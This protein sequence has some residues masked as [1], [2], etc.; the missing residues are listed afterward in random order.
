MSEDSPQCVQSYSVSFCDNMN[1]SD[2]TPLLGAD[3]SDDELDPSEDRTTLKPNHMS[4]QRE[5]PIFI[6]PT[7]KHLNKALSCYSSSCPVNSHDVSWCNACHTRSSFYGGP[8]GK[9]PMDQN[10]DS[11]AKS[12]GSNSGAPQRMVYC[13]HGRPSN[14]CVS[15]LN[16]QNNADAVS[17]IIL[18]DEEDHCHRERK[19]KNDKKAR[20]KLWFASILCLVFM[21]CEIVGGYFSGSLAIATDAAHLLTDFASFMISLIALWVASRPATKQ[22]PFGWYRA[23]VLGAL[24]SVL[25]IWVVTGILLYIAIE[26]VIT[27]NFD[28]EP[29]IMLYTSVFG[30]IVNVLMGC[31][32]HQ[33]S[34]SHGGVREDVNVNVRAAFIHVL[35]DFLQSFGVFVAAVVIYFKP[36]WVLVDPICTF[37]FAL[38]VLA[39][40]FT[41]LRDI[42]IVLM[43]GIPRGV[44]FTDVL[45]TFLD[46]EGV[47]KVHNLRIWA[48]S[49]D[50]AALSAHLAV[51][52]GT[53]AGLIL[54]QASRL[55][56]TKFDFFEMTL[57][58]EEFNA[59]MEACDQCQSPAQ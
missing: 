23:E 8:S 22:M 2:S 56:H 18:D 16:N 40:T 20:R 46:I 45:N 7:T 17:T 1:T 38:L 15:V 30:L 28:I 32:L 26:R 21:I 50:K 9:N 13:V 12:P 59:T 52:P 27:K 53:D 42:M 43:E 57:Q 34:H 35:G 6:S 4:I 31:T 54:K 58:I 33:H 5:S 51:K 11:V 47:E 29:T 55:V 49:L 48:L 24:T 37:L 44:E 25:L 19:N 10:A 36:E 39:T 14:C 41:I 3:Q